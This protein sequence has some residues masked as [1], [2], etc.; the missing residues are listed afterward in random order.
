[1]GV[2]ADEGIKEH[3]K[4]GILGDEDIKEHI[5]ITAAT[6]GSDE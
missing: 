6:D 2:L 4:M 3:I 5:C 1:M